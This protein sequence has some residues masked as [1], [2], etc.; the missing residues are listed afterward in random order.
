MDRVGIRDLRNDTSAVVRRAKAGERII[1]TIDGS[2][3]AVIGPIEEESGAETL[4]ELTERGLVRPPR[5]RGVPPPPKPI[6]LPAGHR[7]TSEI[8]REL[9]ER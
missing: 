4:D 7:T 8:L 5:K 2:P 1:V 9:R 6:S 3:A